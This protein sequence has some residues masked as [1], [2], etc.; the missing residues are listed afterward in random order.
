MPCGLIVH[1]TVKIRLLGRDGAPRFRS[2]RPL[3]P[4]LV[5][6]CETNWVPTR[7]D[8]SEDING[9]HFEIVDLQKNSLHFYIYFLN[10]CGKK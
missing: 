9:I 4:S 1:S 10:A 8:L 7:A 5:T 2:C 3:G 6:D